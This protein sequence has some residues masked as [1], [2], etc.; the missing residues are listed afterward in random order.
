LSRK[1]LV[2][3][4]VL[5]MNV[6]ASRAADLVRLV[7]LKLSAGDLASGVAAVEDYRRAT[8]VDPEYLDAVGWLARGAVM[9]GRP[10]LAGRFVVELRREIPDEKDG[11]LGPYG[12]A[13]EVQGKLIAAREG[14]G[15][16][17][18]Y[19]G[20]QL[21]RARAT[22]VRSRIMKN[23]HL[24]SL[25]GSPAPALAEGS[26][27]SGP[28]TGLDS[29]RGKP[30]LLY[31]WAWGCGDCRAQSASLARVW[32]KYKGTDLQLITATRLYGT[33]AEKPSTPDEERAEIEKVWRELY[34]GLDGV[35]ALISSET[36]ERYGA[37]A[38]PTFALVDRE[39]LVRLY[40][41]TRLS[42]E[43]LSRRIEEVLAERE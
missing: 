7:R 38:T 26:W 40:A 20:R 22:S 31:F 4:M 34:S 36:M 23:I 33:V 29:Y 16:A 18:R 39:G 10:D 42:E 5:S 37:S 28:A 3:L 13:I 43:E 41:P 15:A 21:D 14:R 17:I 8:G 6:G 1:L 11:L 35:G 32:Q 2:I 25:E 24:L 19:L 27:I 12:A 9:L 30:V